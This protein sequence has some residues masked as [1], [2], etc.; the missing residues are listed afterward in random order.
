MRR[1]RRKRRGAWRHTVR[2]SVYDVPPPSL[3]IASEI[4]AVSRERGR[5]VSCPPLNC[6][7]VYQSITPLIQSH[8]YVST[9]KFCTFGTSVCLAWLQC[10]RQKKCTCCLW[11]FHLISSTPPERPSGHCYTFLHRARNKWNI[12]TQVV[13]FNLFLQNVLQGST[14]DGMHGYLFLGLLRQMHGQI[15]FKH[16]ASDRWRWWRWTFGVAGILPTSSS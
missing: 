9:P 6:T 1:L 11:A 13:L 10:E 5:Q 8:R 2:P 14:M 7:S 15:A 12:F 4:R 3:L 16:P